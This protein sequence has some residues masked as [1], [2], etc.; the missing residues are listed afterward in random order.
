MKAKINEIK[1][2]YHVI[3]FHLIRSAEYLP[4]NYK[5]KTWRSGIWLRSNICSGRFQGDIC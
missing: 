4:K 1:D 2:D 3:I 5:G